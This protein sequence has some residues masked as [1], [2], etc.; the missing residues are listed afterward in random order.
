MRS[1]DEVHLDIITIK[2]NNLHMS[3]LIYGFGRL[4]ILFL[5]NYK[6]LF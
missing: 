6:M 4:K 3:W 1:T 2:V 5:V